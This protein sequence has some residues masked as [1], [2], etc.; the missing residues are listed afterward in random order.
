M[1]E[2]LRNEY[3]PSSVSPPGETLAEL[4]AE[5]RISQADFARR[6]GRP[7]K[8][9]NEIVKGKTAISPETALQFERAAG[10]PAAFWLA[11]E[12][13][14]RE[15]RARRADE[16]SLAANADWLKQ[17]PYRDMLAY[18]WIDAAVS[19]NDRTATCLAFFGVASVEAWKSYYSRPV[20]A[21]RASAQ[22]KKAPGAVAAWLRQGEREAESVRLGTYH[23]SAFRNEL[24]A[25]R[26][27]TQESD[28]GSFIPDL[29][30]RCARHGVAVTIVRTPKGCPAYGATR[31]IDPSHA[32]IQLSARHRSDDQFWF[33][34]FHEAGH[35][36]LGPKRET[37]V[38]MED[39]DFMSDDEAKADQFAAD[40][41]IPPDRVQNLASLG[42]SPTKIRAFALSI[43]I[44][45]GIVVGRM[46]KDQLI[47]SH[48]LNNLKNRFNWF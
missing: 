15:W 22:L 30:S 37:F 14:Y 35:V 46:Q 9:I 28:P 23:E 20:A 2:A 1:T 34:F 31:W 18:K 17:L 27:L 5:R 21:F 32:L 16:K 43:G 39:D 25:I 47:G 42:R 29:Q 13:K 26:Q 8:T 33:T 7:L 19:R 10:V 38:D 41:L 48:Q 3:L 40:L 11:R 24:A 12:A 36:L 4:L 44:A 45:P 6:T